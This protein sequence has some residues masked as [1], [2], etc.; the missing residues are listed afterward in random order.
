MNFKVGA[1]AAQRGHPSPPVRLSSTIRPERDG[2]W[3]A[4]SVS[5]ASARS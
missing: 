3:I 1:A 4:S 5:V 2:H